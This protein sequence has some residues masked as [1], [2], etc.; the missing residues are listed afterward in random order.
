MRWR[1]FRHFC[2]VSRMGSEAQAMPT[3]STTLGSQVVLGELEMTPGLPGLEGKG[4]KSQY[5][6]M[7]TSRVY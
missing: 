6:Q 5:V 4:L 1:R 7:L 3:A 2:T